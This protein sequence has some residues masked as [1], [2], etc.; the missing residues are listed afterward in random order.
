VTPVFQK[1][2]SG[3][4]DLKSEEAIANNVITEHMLKR[5]SEDFGGTKGQE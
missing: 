2:F 3:F 1:C 4:K 5:L